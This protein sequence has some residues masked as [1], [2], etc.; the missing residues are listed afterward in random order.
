VFRCREIV[1]LTITAEW[2]G[3]GLEQLVDDARFQARSRPHTF[4]D[5]W[6]DAEHEA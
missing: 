2:Y 4:V 5:Q 1:P 3:A 6:A